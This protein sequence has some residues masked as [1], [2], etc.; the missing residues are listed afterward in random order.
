MQV[1]GFQEPVVI[2]SQNQMP[3]IPLQ[4]SMVEHVP[5]RYLH[6]QFQNETGGKRPDDHQVWTI[7]KA[8]LVFEG[9]QMYPVRGNFVG[10]PFD[11]AEA[12]Q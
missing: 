3:N 1:L 8:F 5:P 6:R 7:P 12:V 11:F 9:M 4:E 10:D 2:C